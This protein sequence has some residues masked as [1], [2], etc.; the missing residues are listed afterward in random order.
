[1]TR[2]VDAFASPMCP[3]ASHATQDTDDGCA[4]D[5][6]LCC[7]AH[8]VIVLPAIPLA[9]LGLLDEAIVVSDSETFAVPPD[10]IEHPPRA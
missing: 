4:G 10:R 6:C 1:M 5:G 8:I 9:P 7:C 3:F 2:Q